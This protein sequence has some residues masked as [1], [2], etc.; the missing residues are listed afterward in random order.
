MIIIQKHQV[1]GNTVKIN[2]LQII[3]VT[4]DFSENNLTDSFKL[5]RHAT[6]LAWAGIRARANFEANFIEK[7]FLSFIIH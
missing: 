4:V 1:Y 6:I 5:N 3:I 7:S 2:Q